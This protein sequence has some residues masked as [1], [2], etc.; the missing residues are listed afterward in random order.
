MGLPVLGDTCLKFTNTS[1]KDQD[2]TVSPRRACNPGFERVS[3]SWGI[4]DGHIVLAGLR[5]PQGDLN[6]DTT[7]TFTFSFQGS[8]DAGIVEGAPSHPSSRSSNFLIV[9]LWTQ[10]R[11]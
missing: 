8:Q 10:P 9:L 5:F 3:V 7:F 4:G 6:G 2:S 1:S 11:L